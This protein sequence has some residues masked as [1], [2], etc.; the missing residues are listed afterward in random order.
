LLFTI[1]LFL[2]LLFKRKKQYHLSNRHERFYECSHCGFEGVKVICGYPPG[3]VF[4]EGTFAFVCG[5]VDEGRNCLFYINNSRLTREVAPPVGE[6][7]VAD[8]AVV[9]VAVDPCEFCGECQKPIINGSCG[10]CK[11]DSCEFC[12]ER[13]KCKCL[14][15][16][17]S[18]P[19]VDENGTK[20]AGEKKKSSCRDCFVCI[21]CEHL[22]DCQHAVECE[23]CNSEPLMRFKDI[24]ASTALCEDC[25]SEFV[26]YEGGDD[27]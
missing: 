3:T 20:I 16:R 11:G 24:S 23:R 12:G 10:G 18:E 22:K 5:N 13:S 8:P 17:C 4:K 2:K 26:A 14:C 9:S 6:C 1:D 25:L 19:Y 7:L 15:P 27:V 21:T